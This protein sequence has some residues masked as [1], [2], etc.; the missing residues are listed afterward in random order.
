MSEIDSTDT[1]K[2]KRGPVST[3]NADVHCNMAIVA[4]QAGMT[5]QEFADVIGISRAVLH[6]WRKNFPEFKKAFNG[7]KKYSDEKVVKSLYE[8]A[9]G[10]EYQ[11]TE[12]SDGPKGVT[13]KQQNKQMAPDVT[14]QIF[15]LKNRRPEEWRDRHDLNVTGNIDYKDQRGKL[16]KLFDRE[17]K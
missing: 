16:K 10:Y 11:E 13:T 6:E 7:G 2:K 4:G 12:I 1:K 5:D 9:M 3:Y 15:W 8:R 14:A 17:N